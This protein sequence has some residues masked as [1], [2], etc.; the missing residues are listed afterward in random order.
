MQRDDTWKLLLHLAGTLDFM[1]LQYNTILVFLVAF[2]CAW[3][4]N[5]HEKIGECVCMCEH[6][7]V[8]RALGG[9]L[10][11]YF[12]QIHDDF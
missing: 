7:D 5:P 4:Q 10:R 11:P 8:C 9:T 12:I 3:S 6:T 2:K 1:F